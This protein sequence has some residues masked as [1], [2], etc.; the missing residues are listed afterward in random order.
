MVG[1]CHMNP[2]R[3]IRS[4]AFRII[5]KLVLA[6]HKLRSIHVGRDTYCGIESPPSRTVEDPRLQPLAE[7]M[8][9]RL[10]SGDLFKPLAVAAMQGVEIVALF[11]DAGGE[12]EYLVCLGPKRRR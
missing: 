12:E 8:Q 4:C 9:A 7:E 5:R 3:T 11:R 10:Q 6:S 1:G 2:I